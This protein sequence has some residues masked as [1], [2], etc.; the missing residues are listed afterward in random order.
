[1]THAQETHGWER[2]TASASAS[3]CGMDPMMAARPRYVTSTLAGRRFLDLWTVEDSKDPCIPPLTRVK[4][5]SLLYIAHGMYMALHDGKPLVSEKVR[6]WT[7]G[8]IFAEVFNETRMYGDRA[9]QNVPRGQREMISYDVRL[10]PEETGVIDAV[11]K[12][13]KYGSDT[14]L[15]ALNHAVGTPWHDTWDGSEYKDIDNDLIFRF[16]QN[17]VECSCPMQNGQER[18]VQSQQLSLDIF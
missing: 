12:S 18:S 14:Q 2:S 6:A 16:F 10:S 3:P 13:Y 17:L 7:Y 1:M 4:L 9:I 15:I 8:P 11:Y 5:V